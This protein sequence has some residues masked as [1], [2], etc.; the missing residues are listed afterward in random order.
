LTRAIF[1]E[2]G[3]DPARVL[4][5]TSAAFPRPAPRPA[6]SVLGDQ[7]WRSAGLT[8]L[9]GWRE[10]LHASFQEAGEAFREQTE[11]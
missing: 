5:T 8:P 2:I 9:R 6:F 3:A 7:A 10:A 1:E 4:P 11:R